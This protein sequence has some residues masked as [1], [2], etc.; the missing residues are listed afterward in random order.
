MSPRKID[1]YL[2][3]EVLGPFTGA[4]IF[5]LFISLM[6]QALRLTEF[7]IVHGVPGGMLLKMAGLLGLSFMPTALPVAFLVAVLVA[8]GRLSADGELV[9]MKACGI[10]VTRLAV[11]VLMVSS[12]IVV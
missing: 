4:L 11:P 2:V 8:F 3:S 5:F 7:F 6:F 9:A 1:A 12:V 10:G